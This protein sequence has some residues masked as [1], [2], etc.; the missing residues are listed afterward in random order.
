M[1]DKLLFMGLY[2]VGAGIA[3]PPK[4]GTFFGFCKAKCRTTDGRPYEV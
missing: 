2:N 1:K 4:N 3:R